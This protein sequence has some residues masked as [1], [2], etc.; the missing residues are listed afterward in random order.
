MSEPLVINNLAKLKRLA[1]SMKKQAAAEGHPITHTEALE[2]VAK[3]AGFAN[4]KDASR[5]MS[6]MGSN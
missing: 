4:Y 5:K 3:I 1:K 6:G 2:R